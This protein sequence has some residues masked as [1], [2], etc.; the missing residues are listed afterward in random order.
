M[1]LAEHFGSSE[2]TEVD[3]LKKELREYFLEAMPQGS[4][5][6]WL[7]KSG[8]KVVATSGMVMW[9][10]PPNNSIKNGKLGY[11]LNMYTVPEARG[12]G[13]CTTLLEK[14]I[15]EAKALGLNRVHLHASKMGEPIYRKRGFR[16][17]GDV[18]LVMRI[19]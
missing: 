13:I 14:L 11:I 2:M 5:I 8:D 12:Q 6:A 19:E 10:I 3:L 18:E 7:A 9:K 16:E 1:F 4:F 17:P 15:D